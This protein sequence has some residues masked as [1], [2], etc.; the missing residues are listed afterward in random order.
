MVA[1]IMQIVTVNACLIARIATAIAIAMVFPIARTAARTNLAATN[2]KR[3]HRTM[4][5]FFLQN[6][7]S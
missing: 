2:K 5:A 3:Q 7:F 1:R 4:L 6:S